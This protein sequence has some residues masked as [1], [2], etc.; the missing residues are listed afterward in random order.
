VGL[1]LVKTTPLSNQVHAYLSANAMQNDYHKND[2]ER[3][4]FGI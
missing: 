4:I 3:Q 1:A 2:K